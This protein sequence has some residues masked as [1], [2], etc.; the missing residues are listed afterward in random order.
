MLVLDASISSLT[1]ARMGVCSAGLTSPSLSLAC[2]PM[3]KAPWTS[4]AQ[5]GPG[6][7]GTLKGSV[8]DGHTAV[9]PL[10]CSP[11]WRGMCWQ[12]AWPSGL[13]SVSLSL[14]LPAALWG[15]PMLP[16]RF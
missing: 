6:E 8:P 15:Q 13:P 11:G 10:P 3:L 9:G 1:P 12:P 4:G 16:G 2:H 7:P 5:G 14:V